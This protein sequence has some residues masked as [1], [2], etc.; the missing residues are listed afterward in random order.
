MGFLIITIPYSFF[1]IMHNFLRKP[2][3]FSNAHF[4]TA[5][6]MVVSYYTYILLQNQHTYI[7]IHKY[8]H[9]YIHAKPKY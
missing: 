1:Q 7:Y 4:D 9:T 5:V 2:S 6:T 3:A 8:I